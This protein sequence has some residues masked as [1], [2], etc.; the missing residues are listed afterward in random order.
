MSDDARMELFDQ[1]IDALL[2]GA[3]QASA[4]A[5]FA[6][7]I[8]VAGVLR[9]L[10][11]E[12]FKDRLR[13]HLERKTPMTASSP[14]AAFTI[15]AVTPFLTVAEGDRLIEFLKQTF[16]AEETA[17]APHGPD[18]FVATVRIADSDLLILSGESV[19]GQERPAALHV[20]VKDTD[21]VYRRAI[22]AG[23]I[24][25]PPG[26]G[27][28][29]DRPYGERS[30][31]VTDLAGNQW[32]IATRPGPNYIA[33]GLKAVTPYLHPAK[34]RPVIDFLKRAFGAEEMAV[35]EHEGRVMHAVI[36]VGEAMLE[37]GEADQPPVSFYVY[38]GDVDAVYRS[39]LAAGAASVL[40]PADQSYGDRLAIVRDPFGNLWYPAKRIA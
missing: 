29:A 2:R 14:T 12:S 21:A 28:P 22:D 40:A 36:R 34:A 35:Y 11:E 8:E 20:Y 6:A 18:G 4:D 39:A 25:T 27:E 10:P 7:L 9:D 30:A 33:E 13:E 17:R 5:E 3:P 26:I 31:F 32:Y 19:R 15:D 1:A 16:D 24:T 38:T 23:A 37:M